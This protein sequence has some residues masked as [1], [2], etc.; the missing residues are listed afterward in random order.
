MKLFKVLIIYL[1]CFPLLCLSY[2]RL[3]KMCLC[4]NM[5]C[6][7]IFSVILKLKATLNGSFIGDPSHFAEWPI[8]PHGCSGIFISSEA[9]IG[10]GC[11]IFQQVTIGSNSLL[12]SKG[13]GAPVIGENVYIG[14]G[15]KIIGKVR[16]GN[17]VRIGANA[18]VVHDV[19]DNCTVIL[20]GISIIERE[21]PPNNTFR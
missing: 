9:M 6:A 18:V 16:V 20:R 5:I 10:K 8:L 7:K 1:C 21:V 4:S 17:H 15:A 2:R 11:V 14:A 3:H 13:L 12:D 19:P